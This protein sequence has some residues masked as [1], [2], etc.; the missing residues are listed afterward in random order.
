MAS[1]RVLTSSS[2]NFIV[3]PVQGEFHDLLEQA[4][5]VHAKHPESRQPQEVHHRHMVELSLSI[6][7]FHQGVISVTKREA[8]EN[9]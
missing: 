9:N 3:L 8:C 2:F 4:R 1:G 5:R 7:I 6:N